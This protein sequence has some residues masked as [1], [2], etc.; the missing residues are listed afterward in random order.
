[1]CDIYHVPEEKIACEYL[2]YLNQK[3]IPI[4]Q[5]P[6]LEILE[7]FE[8]ETLKALVSSKNEKQNG[9]IVV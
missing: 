9:P 6:T 7:G 4:N 3:K 5:S 1:M 2:A 8:T